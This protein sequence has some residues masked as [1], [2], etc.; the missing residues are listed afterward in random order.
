[1][2][3]NTSQTLLFFKVKEQVLYM[4]DLCDRV[5]EALPQL[6]SLCTWHLY[7]Q[8][9]RGKKTVKM[10]N[11]FGKRQ[12]ICTVSI[13]SL[14]VTLIFPS[15]IWRLSLA[16]SKLRS[17]LLSS[18]IEISPLRSSVSMYWLHTHALIYTWAII[19]NKLNL[20]LAWT[21]I[22]LITYIGIFL[23]IEKEQHV[24]TQ[25]SPQF[26]RSLHT[27]RQVDKKT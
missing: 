4:T 22:S 3:S 27:Q 15:F 12:K 6:T 5:D 19:N 24:S 1:M 21:Q 20:T 26:P 18:V 10:R 14:T 7:K 9:K 13:Y 2:H 8:Q 16:A 17:W 23:F 11:Y 25:A